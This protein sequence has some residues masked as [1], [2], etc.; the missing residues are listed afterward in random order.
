MPKYAVEVQYL[1]PVWACVI[2]EAED[3]EKA[4]QAVIFDESGRTWDNAAED[5]DSALHTTIEGCREISD[6]EIEQLGDNPAREQLHDVI[7]GTDTAEAS[8]QK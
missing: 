7:H 3:A 6:E 2:V 5:Y 8:P 1:L 4:K